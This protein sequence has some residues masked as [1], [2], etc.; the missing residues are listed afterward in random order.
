MALVWKP[1][2]YKSSTLTLLPRPVHTLDIMDKWEFEES[3]VPKRDGCRMAGHSRGPRRIEV[4]G[5]LGSHNGTPTISED[6]QLA[7]MALLDA[8]IDIDG[9][10]RF[11]FFIY[12]D[13]VGPSYRKYKNCAPD[14]M[15]WSLGDEN[16]S[17]M[18]YTLSI[19]AEDPALYPTA[20]GA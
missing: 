8:A 13:T 5:E 6:D 11:E 12:H 7:A 18:A 4:T 14:A 3:K 9:E 1:A 16:R 2:I 17:P 15:K 20:P 19:I 10:T